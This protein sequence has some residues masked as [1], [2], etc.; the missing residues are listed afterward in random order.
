MGSFST[1]DTF[2]CYAVLVEAY[3]DYV[4]PPSEAKGSQHILCVAHGFR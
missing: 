3:Y 2:I 1:A 4:L